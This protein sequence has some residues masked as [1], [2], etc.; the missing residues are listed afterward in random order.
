MKRVILMIYVICTALLLKAEMRIWTGK[1]GQTFEA[2]YVRDASGKVWLKPQQG[3]TRVVPV[4]ALTQEDQNYILKK[5]LPKLE[6]HVDDDIKRSTVGSDIDNVAADIR[7]SVEIKKTS[8][9]PYPVEYEMFFCVL[10]MD[11][12]Y[13]EYY[14]AEKHTEKFSLDKKGDIFRFKGM[15]HY[16]E[17]DPDPAWGTR[18]EGYVLTVKTVEGIELLTKGPDKFLKHVQKLKEGDVKRTRFRKNF[19]IS[20]RSRR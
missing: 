15:D 7:H 4:D 12:R 2:E 16:F 3:K 20:T 6:A 14:I 10:A 19:E 8:R 5:T 11:I 9:M 17:Y 13:K 1:N 18:Y